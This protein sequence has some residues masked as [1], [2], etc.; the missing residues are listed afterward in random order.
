MPAFGQTTATG[1]PPFTSMS[2][3]PDQVNLANLNVHQVI[4]VLHKAGRGLPLIFDIT[5]DT[6]IWYQ[7][8]GSGGQM[9]W[10]PLPTAGWSQSPANV[11]MLD[12]SYTFD[13]LGD[14]FYSGFTYYDGGGTPHELS[15]DS[16]GCGNGA[17]CYLNCADWNP[18][19]SISTNGVTAFDDSGY[20]LNATVDPSTHNLVVGLFTA[21][22]TAIV[23][24]NFNPTAP[25]ASSG[26][27]YDRNGNEITISN[28]TIT[29]T[30]GTT[31]LQ[32]SGGIAP[33]RSETP[34]TFTYTA[35]SGSQAAV[36][37]NYES[38]TID[39]NFQCSNVVDY[40]QPSGIPN[41]L[42]SSIVLPDG[43]S[44]QFH[45]EDTPG[46]PGATTGRLTSVILPTGGTIS[47]QYTGSN[48]GINCSDGSPL[49]L[50]RT[51]PDGT[52]TYTR[53]FGSGLSTTNVTD[54]QGNVTAIQFAGLYETE[55]QVYNGTQVPA[56]LLL[57]TYDCY[58]NNKP[59]QASCASGVPPSGSFVLLPI[60]ERSVFVQLPSGQESEQDMIYNPLGLETQETDYDYGSNSPGVPLR[61]SAVVYHNFGSGSQINNLPDSVTVTDGSGNI[62]A[63]TTYVYD[64]S[65]P[66]ASSGTPQHVTITGPR[67]NAT[68][69]AR[70][71]QGTYTLAETFTYFDTGQVNKATDVN[72]TYSIYNYPDA[73]STCGNAFPTFLNEPNGLTESF[74]WN[75]TGGVLASRTDA[76]G[77]VQSVSYNDP[78]FW[79]PHSITDQMSNITTL[80]YIGQNAV[81]SSLPVNG[82]STV[83][84]LTTLDSLGRSQ[85]LQT[86]EAPASTNYDSVQ[87]HYDSLGRLSGATVPY[88][89]AGSQLCSGTCPSTSIQQ[90]ALSRPTSIADAGG[91]TLSIQYPYNDVYESLGP[92]PTGENT[93]DK[94]LEYD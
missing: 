48:N 23:P 69:I 4:P 29:D 53:S 56:H 51:T 28:G 82:S 55:R 19:G 31:A 3:G 77:K 80:T 61:Q 27:T 87:D 49:G 42:V 10:A 67:G 93:K 52:W 46:I 2:G 5:Y 73:T 14:V 8:Q 34:Q 68:T 66:A 17:A 15:P 58:N 47:Y 84:Q 21:N 89:A 44:Y 91:A 92:K 60:T 35:P 6:T 39:T 74:A 32:I 22:G 71:A 63:Q 26:S 16:A 45:Y 86:K 65:T 12:Y 79:R 40:V 37:V 20:T 41:Y 1:V 75:C 94:Q 59:Q 25:G 50:T 43:S 30:L 76:N 54:P 11:G 57:T 81:E 7:L 85:I 38:A 18:C 72:G 70:L 24:Q 64:A 33:D 83:D 9:Y 13:N 90:D 88:S 78:Y 62:D 36:T